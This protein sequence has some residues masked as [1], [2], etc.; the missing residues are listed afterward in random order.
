MPFINGFWIEP[1]VKTKTKQK[2]A[3]SQVNLTFTLGRPV[4]DT[5]RIIF[6][7]NLRNNILSPEKSLLNSNVDMATLK[8]SIIQKID[9]YDRNYMKLTKFSTVKAT[10]EFDSK[11]WLNDALKNVAP[12]NRLSKFEQ[13]FKFKIQIPKMIQFSITRVNFDKYIVRRFKEYMKTHNKSR[14]WFTKFL[15][16]EIAGKIRLSIS[17]MFDYEYDWQ[18]NTMV[19]KLKPV[20]VMGL[21][22]AVGAATSKNVRR[23]YVKIDFE[24]SVKRKRKSFDR[25]KWQSFI[26]KKFI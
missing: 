19:A 7:V 8:K 25:K 22:F 12:N 24:K 13:R 10:F 15:P 17:T 23:N 20:Y 1:E 11:K 21:I 3:P 5:Y 18:T 14:T 9:P 4:G 26:K 16:R 2:I 6:M